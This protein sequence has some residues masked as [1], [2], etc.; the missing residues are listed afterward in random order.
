MEGPHVS[1]RQVLTAAVVT[2]A[3]GAMMGPKVV[4]AN[5]QRRLGPFSDWSEPVWLGP[6]DGP[7]SRNTLSMRTVDT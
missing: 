3:V 5:H 4:F 6:V 7:G 2:G 1:R